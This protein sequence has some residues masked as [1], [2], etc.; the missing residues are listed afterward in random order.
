MWERPN[1]RQ[2]DD[3]DYRAYLYHY[4]PEE[5]SEM[6]LEVR[7]EPQ[8]DSFTWLRQGPL[9]ALVGMQQG[10]ERNRFWVPLIWYGPHAPKNLLPDRLHHLFDDLETEPDPEFGAP[11]RPPGVVIVAADALA[12]ARAST[13]SMLE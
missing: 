11:A 6:Q 3:E 10:T 4:F 7:S 9:H 12:A 8:P 5:Y 1:S 2:G 13:Q